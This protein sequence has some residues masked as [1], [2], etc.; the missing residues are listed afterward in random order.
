MSVALYPGSF[1]PIHNG[2]LQV[3]ETIAPLFDD[4]IVGVG[5]N[6]EKPSG[7]FTPDERV[8]MIRSAVAGLTN[9]RVELFVGLATAAAIGFG[10]DCLVKG[11]RGAGDLDAEM[12]QAAMNSLTAGVP[13]LFAPAM[14]EASLV[15]SR[16]VREIAAM[17][18][19]INSVVPSAVA[20]QLN[21]RFPS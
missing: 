9:V 13:T 7:L 2:H 21:E 4:L 10:A 20:A 12:Q 16:Y 19:D 14:G 3:I 15:S 5:H 6:P 18:G 11:V 8:A 1:D 17:G